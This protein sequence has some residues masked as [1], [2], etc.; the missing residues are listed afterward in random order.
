MLHF[1]PEAQSPENQRTQLQ[2]D[3]FYRLSQD[4]LCAIGSDGYFRELNPRWEETLGWANAELF[5]QSYWQLIHPNDRRLTFAKLQELTANS[6]SIS[7]KNRC[8]CTDN[9]YKWL[10][11]NVTLCKEQQLIYAVVRDIT[12]Y[13][14]SKQALRDSEERFRCLVENVKD[15]AIYMLDPEGRVISWNQGAERI[16]GYREEEIIGQSVSCLYPP[17]DVATGKPEQELHLAATVGRFEDESYRIRSNGSRFWV[18]AVITALY[19]SNGQLRGFAKVVRD[20][21]ERKQAE[22]ALKKAYDELERRVEERTIELSQSNQRL[23]WEIAEREQVEAELR[24]SEAQLREQTQHLQQTLHEL[25]CTQAR[26]VQSEKMSSLGQL[27][28]GIAHEINNP[29]TFIAGNLDYAAFHI[30]DLLHHLQLYQQYYSKPAAEI[31]AQAEAIDLNFLVQDLPKL[32]QSMKV[33]A[34]RIHQ[35]VLSLRNFSHLGSAQRKAIDIHKGI[36]DTLLILQNR[37]KAQAGKPTIAVIKEYGN[38]PL[39][40]CYGGQ[41]NQVFMN[42]L[43]NAIDALTSDFTN[44]T[45]EPRLKNEKWER[46]DT[47]TI[48]EERITVPRLP[49]WASS[50]SHSFIA[51]CQSQIPTI[52]ICTELLDKDWV[53]IRIADNG[54]GMTE[55]VKQQ[56]FDPFF[57]TKPVGKGVGLGLSISYQIIVEKHGGQLKCFSAP[58]WG[59]EFIVEIPVRCTSQERHHERLQPTAVA[60]LA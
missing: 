42:I 57:T 45:L 26:L 18:N 25:K 17:E 13:Q 3:Y 14:Q 8:R 15:Y 55:K 7:F 10:L 44:D 23:R 29:V 11:W 38:L 35:L 19:D 52:R 5:A 59:T 58:G 20:I 50:S 34:A 6:E 4:M 1:F 60:A 46:R 43:N 36:D 53:A 56:L 33:G 39:V 27:V 31:Q 41:L 28:A 22:E 40:E 12:K 24:H 21:T 37:L 54:I 48:A 9:S 30:Q 49:L 2:I 32:L 51:N 16:N 47:K